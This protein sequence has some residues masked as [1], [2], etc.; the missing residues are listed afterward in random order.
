MSLEMRAFFF[1]NHV[2][3]TPPGVS[4]RKSIEISEVVSYFRSPNNPV[5]VCERERAR[6]KISE[7]MCDVSFF[8]IHNNNIYIL[9]CICAQV[10]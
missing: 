9:A 3:S 10:P 5:G 7:F 6:E 2:R 4:A 1:S 8:F